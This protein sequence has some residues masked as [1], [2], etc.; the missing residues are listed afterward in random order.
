ML[1]RSRT[2]AYPAMPHAVHDQDHALEH[3]RRRLAAGSAWVATSED[4]VTGFALTT[5]GWLEMLF[6]DPDHAGHGV[7]STL[8]DVVKHAQRDG[9]ALWVFVSNEP[10]RRFYRR[11]GLVELEVT[12]GRDNEERQP[13]LRMA[14]PGER[15]LDYLR[16]QVD[17]ADDEL[18]SLMLRRLA[19]TREIQRHK[20]VPGHSGRDPDR[21][22]EIAARLAD[23][24][25]DLSREEWQRIVHAVISASLD[26][27]ARGE[28]TDPPHD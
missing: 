13:D 4:M 22:L 12:D 21:E 17:R 8:L 15:P 27:V 2:A 19:L 5:P 24:A 18:A 1:H 7:G 23:Q 26:S 6:V 9:F 3:L 25:P 14:W 16:G 20:P 10:A 28:R 11:R